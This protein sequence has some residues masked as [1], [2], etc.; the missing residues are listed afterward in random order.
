MKII[1]SNPYGEISFDRLRTFEK[2]VGAPLPPDYRQYLIDHNGG[3]P[4]NTSFK[5]GKENSRLHNM[6]GINDGPDF[7]NMEWNYD[8][9]KDRIP[10]KILPI[11]DDPFGNLICLGIAK[12][13]YDK[14][15]FW[16]HE[17]ERPIIEISLSFNQFVEDLYP[18]QK[19]GNDLTQAIQDNDIS[20]IKRIVEDGFDLEHEDEYNRTMME[21]AAIYNRPEIIEFLYG[22]GAKVRNSLQYAQDNLEFFP[23]QLETVELLKKMMERPGRKG[24]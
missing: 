12:D 2:L 10:K 20:Y 7:Q 21:N 11:G 22:R 18:T 24:V 14:V 5:I 9:F 16:D 8:I 17:I 15:F 13:V 4:K 19:L 1:T 3:M 6:F 23:D